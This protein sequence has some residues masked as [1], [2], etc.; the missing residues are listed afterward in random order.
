MV[1]ATPIEAPSPYA[2]PRPIGALQVD[3]GRSMRP[4]TPNITGP[5]STVITG[6]PTP[7]TPP[8]ATIAPIELLPSKASAGRPIVPID[9]DPPS[10]LVHLHQRPHCRP[11]GW[12]HNG[13]QQLQFRRHN[14][15]SCLISHRPLERQVFLVGE[16]DRDL[17]VGSKLCLQL[18]SKPWTG[19]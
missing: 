16:L 6:L 11:L 10:R 8:S 19:R 14:A 9:Y 2:A 13:P 3:V 15:H 4:S 7:F 18:T 5:S 17:P 1:I 12:V